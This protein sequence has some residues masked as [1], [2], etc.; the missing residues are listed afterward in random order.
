M[1]LVAVGRWC[2][3]GAAIGGIC[4][5]HDRTVQE[6]S[7]SGDRWQ[8]GSRARCRPGLCSRGS[9][10]RD[11]RERQQPWRGSP[12]GVGSA[13]R[14]SRIRPGI[15]ARRRRRFVKT[16]DSKHKL[17]VAPNLRAGAE[18]APSWSFCLSPPS[19]LAIRIA[20]RAGLAQTGTANNHGMRFRRSP[21]PV[22]WPSAPAASRANNRFI[23]LTC[24][25]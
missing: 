3:Q 1:V 14:P 6:S 20:V 4:G 24:V 21:T 22:T 19:S 2:W 10:S 9:V 7:R 25:K 13:R 12:E 15:A 23:V 8:L 16:T 18:G 11:C 17:P 5:R